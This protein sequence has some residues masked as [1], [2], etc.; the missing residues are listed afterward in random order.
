MQKQDSSSDRENQFAVDA[1]K[2]ISEALPNS[3][4]RLLR[5][6]PE[7]ETEVAKDLEIRRRLRLLRRQ[8]LL[9]PQPTTARLLQDEARVGVTGAG[10]SVHLI[11]TVVVEPG[12]QW[13]GGWFVATVPPNEAE[14]FQHYL[15]DAREA[16][17]TQLRQARS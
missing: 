8:A 14:R 11:L 13:A 7:C 2:F 17:I 9:A 16:T 1:S 10:A 12:G 3:G 4:I 15:V 5:S 6:R